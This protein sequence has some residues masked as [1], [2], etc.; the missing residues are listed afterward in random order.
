MA[1][2]DLMVDSLRK[3][4]EVHMGRVGYILHAVFIDD[5]ALGGY[6][7]DIEKLA[8]NVLTRFPECDLAVL[9]IEEFINSRSDVDWIDLAEKADAGILSESEKDVIG[10]LR[11]IK[12]RSSYQDIVHLI[13]RRIGAMLAQAKGWQ[14]VIYGDSMTRLAESIISLTAKGRGQSI[15]SQIFPEA[16][17]PSI[18]YPMCEI[19]SSEI[20]DYVKIR[21][22]DT[23]TA[24]LLEPVPSTTRLQSVDEL[25]RQYFVNV[26]K[27]FPTIVS[28]V[29]RAAAKLAS[30]EGVGDHKCKLCGARCQ[31]DNNQWLSGITVN[32][33]QGS[34]STAPAAIADPPLCY[35]C[36]VMCRDVAM[37]SVPWPRYLK[38][39]ILDEYILDGER[40]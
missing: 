39:D 37:P 14:T 19:L 9:P 35:G 18:K 17:K 20:K 33:R 24:S 23:L 28:T 2:L 16:A 11:S 34:E 1:L 29:V 30:P 26:E 15:P 13:I 4:K 3:Q 40:E 8:S 5:R 32:Y 38:E 21:G 25:V 6:N 10:I 12:S 7:S 27:G 22:L 31:G 36:I